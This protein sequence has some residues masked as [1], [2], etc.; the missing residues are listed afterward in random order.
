MATASRTTQLTSAQREHAIKRIREIADAAKATIRE[1]HTSPEVKLTKA[2]KQ[3]LVKSG[4]V[5]LSTTKAIELW[6]DYRRYVGDLFDFSAHEKPAVLSP[7]GKN[8]IAAIDKQVTVTIDKVILGDA[9]YALEAI[10][11][12][13]KS[14]KV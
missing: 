10:Q 8:K 1:K 14:L 13:E 9:S 5:K 12:F 7:V 6:D 11:N 4:K 3:A 2:Q